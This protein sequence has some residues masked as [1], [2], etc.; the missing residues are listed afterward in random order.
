MTK[1]IYHARARANTGAPPGTL[2][3]AGGAL[4]IPLKAWLAL[5]MAKDE[6][7]DGSASV[8]PAARAAELTR[9]GAQQV[10][11]RGQQRQRAAL[12]AATSQATRLARPEPLACRAASLGLAG[13]ATSA[14]GFGREVTQGRW[15]GWGVGG[16]G[17]ASS[18]GLRGPLGGL[19]LAQRLPSRDGAARPAPACPAPVTLI[20]SEG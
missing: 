16:G 10:Q 15:G 6:P 3:A 18:V 1:A 11:D 20:G 4:N 13:G 7:S 9:R 17:G 12:A 14:V 19:G 5:A 2:P 8:P